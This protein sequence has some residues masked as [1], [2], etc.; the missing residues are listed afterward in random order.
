M[1]CAGC[2]SP[3]TFGQVI[4][5]ST[6]APFDRSERAICGGCWAK[7]V[8]LGRKAAAVREDSANLS[9]MAVDMTRKESGARVTA[10]KLEM[11]NGY[12][13][14]GYAEESF[15]LRYRACCGE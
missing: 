5:A 11:D 9:G 7:L 2:G 15:L 12:K 6:A 13:A 3:D 4:Y 1:T 14:I 8:E 10:I